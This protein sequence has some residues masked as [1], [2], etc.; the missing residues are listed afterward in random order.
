MISIPII[1]VSVS[2][3][4]NFL[5]YLFLSGR[6]AVSTGDYLPE[7]FNLDFLLFC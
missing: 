2:E 4:Y 6:V 7:D 5:D 3:Y 1:M